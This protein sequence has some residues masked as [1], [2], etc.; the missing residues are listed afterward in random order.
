[1]FGIPITKGI[2]RLSDNS[3]SLNRIDNDKGYVKG[4]VEILS[5]RAN[6]LINDGTLEE[7]RKIVAYIGD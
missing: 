5:N 7:F 1:V 2:G 4:N 6:R 3:P